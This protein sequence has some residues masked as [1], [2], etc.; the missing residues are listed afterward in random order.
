MTGIA[1]VAVP[2]SC[3]WLVNGWWLGRRQE[4][5]VK[6]PGKVSLAGC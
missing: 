1:L 2:I 5:M 4:E 6:E 3:A